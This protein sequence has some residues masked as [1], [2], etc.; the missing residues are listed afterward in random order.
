MSQLTAAQ[1]AVYPRPISTDAPVLYAEPEILAEDEEP[2]LRRYWRTFAR[3]R[4]IIAA[5]LGVCIAIALLVTLLSP[6]EFTATTSI[7]VAREAPKVV[8][9]QST[10][11]DQPDSSSLEFYQTQY[12]LLKSRSLSEQVAKDLQLPTNIDFLT[13]G[14][15]SERAKITA[16]PVSKRLELA[17][18][19]VN[20]RTTISPVRG[21]S[22]IDIE[23]RDGSPV[24]AATVANSIAQNFIQSSLSRRFESAAYARDFLQRKLDQTR[25]KLEE[26]ERRAV[27]YAQREGL[28][29]IQTGTADNPTEQ[30]LVASQ[31][32][33]LSTQLTAARAAR[34]QAESQFTAGRSGSV[35]A[36]SL[37][38]T[39]VNGLR[40]SRADLLGQLSKLQSDF[41]PEYPPVI[42]L[43][44]QIAELDRQIAQEQ[45]RVS[46][47]VALDAGGRYQQA[48]AA[49]RSLQSKVDELKSQLL[50]EQTR[51]IQFN[52]LQRDVDTNRA[53]YEALLQ[54]FKEVGIA[55]GVGTNN[56]SIVDSAL[57]PAFASSPNLWLNLALGVLV[58]LLAGVI[59]A[60]VL[61]QLAEAVVLPTE[62]Q[63]KLKVPL[64]GTTPLTGEKASSP[65]LVAQSNGG[66]GAKLPAVQEDGDLAEA[67]FSIL[68]AVQF[69]AAGGA[70]RVISITSSQPQEGKSTSAL[71]LARG[72]ASTGVRVLLIDADM[73]NPSLHRALGLPRDRGLSDVLTSN[74]K[75][76]DV[77]HPTPFKGL[78][79]MTAG[80]IPPNA[81][82]LLASES[83]AGLI[84]AT[85]DSFDHVIFDSPPVLGLADAPLLARAADGTV[86][87][88]EAGRTRSTQARQA[89]DRLRSVQAHILGAVLTKLDRKK[90]GY[91]YG[92]GYSYRYGPTAP[93]QS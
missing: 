49:E 47:S 5:A 42:A 21:S 51:S 57:P 80:R 90:S 82:E 59:G 69:S 24:M 60:L 3:H 11:S 91:G 67:Y 77:V 83:L 40:A 65:R 61:E 10:D 1:P 23:Y 52:I 86:F 46:S 35:A 73:R 92:Y 66:E 87:V 43:K 14:R 38:S 29:K 19:K 71:A 30:S 72:L 44:S 33:E 89:L 56:V 2:I 6:R 75:L 84:K 13:D 85:R 81:A 28:I 54:R 20:E 12:A 70:P 48:L 26:S 41:G 50:G 34:V 64:L 93:A 74:A 32:S 16:M 25:A 76:S 62:F 88:M 55:G 15:A 7:Q 9:M 18:N 58:G 63:S 39:T 36:Q 68:T 45:A 22:I 4:W 8:D 17:A 31:L 78:T 79:V 53:L 27:E 37:T